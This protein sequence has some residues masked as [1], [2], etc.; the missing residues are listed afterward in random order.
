MD[1]KQALEALFEHAVEGIL[2]AD[3]WGAISRINPAAE[4]MF[5]YEAG[6]L[7][8][9]K[10]EALVPYNVENKHERLRT[11]FW[12]NPHRRATGVAM[13]LF[14]KRKN[15]SEFPVEISLSPVK[16][17]EGNQIVIA[18][19]IDVTKRKAQDEMLRGTLRDLQYFSEGLK[20]SNAELQ[21]FAYVASHDLQEPLRKIQSF[22]E[23]LKH[24]EADKFSEH[25]K[26]YL[27][28]MLNAASRMQILINDLL[29]FSRLTAGAKP[30]VP[31]DLNTLLTEVMSDME[32]SIDQA[33]AQI[34]ASDLPVIDAE[35]TQMRQLF[36]N[37]ISNAI[38]FRRAGVD[39]VIRIEA[40]RVDEGKKLELS[41]Q[42][43]GIGFEEKHTDSIF[44]IFQRLE[45]KRVEGSGIGLAICRKI[46]EWHGGTI[47]AKGDLGK[48]ATF[49]LRMP[50]NHEDT[51]RDVIHAL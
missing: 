47:T 26:D 16:T 42:D 14:G 22:G 23:R 29:L 18:Y 46:A 6:E 45:G 13:D 36:Q 49:T 21:N 32:V 43:N 15:N 28:R 1:S 17:A 10:I 19:I 31:V 30:F 34:V 24:L 27:G 51:A 48:G 35:P 4:R 11:E 12:E 9:K 8:G 39:L 7:L 20:V 25:G 41:F 33:K 38:K 5:G 40:S 44:N 37:L 2:I 3:Q 50:P